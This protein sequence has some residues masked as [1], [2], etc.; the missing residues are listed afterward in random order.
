MSSQTEF[1]YLTSEGNQVEW[2]WPDFT[3]AEM[4]CRCRNCTSVID[5]D[6]MDDL[7]ALR[8][9]FGSPMNITS[10]HRC[11]RHNASIGGAMSSGHVTAQAVDVAVG[12][13]KAYELVGKA[14]NH[15]FSR[16]GVSQRDDSRFIHIGAER[17]DETIWSY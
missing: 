3:P 8:N 13:A 9:D 1:L 16:I 7:Q 14:M 10:G 17:P 6:F 2:R 11:M 5:E 4:L 12:G 15:G